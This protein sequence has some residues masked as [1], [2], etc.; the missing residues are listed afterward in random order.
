MEDRVEVVEGSPDKAGPGKPF[1]GQPVF[2]V[3]GA[4]VGFTRL[5]PGAVTPWHHHGDCNF[6]G[7]VVQGT[8]TLE[9]GHGGRQS[10]QISEGRFLRIPPRLVHRDANRTG[11]T[12]LIATA[13]VG[14]KP[15]S[16]LVDA[17]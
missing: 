12:V 2:E 9:F 1:G 3:A 16:V 11:E 5:A 14:E 15:T 13:C 8:V 7:F 17:P 10:E 6:F 4:S